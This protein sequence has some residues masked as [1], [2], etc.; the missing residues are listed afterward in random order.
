MMGCFFDVS[1]PIAPLIYLGKLAKSRHEVEDDPRS[2]ISMLL[3]K[4][5]SPAPLPTS[6]F[7]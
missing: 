3:K 5:S 6:N 7:V 4:P 1:P 2:M